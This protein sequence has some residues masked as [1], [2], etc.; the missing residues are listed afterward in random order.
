MKANEFELF[1]STATHEQM[2]NFFDSLLFKEMNL[3]IKGRIQ[4]YNGERKFKY[5]AMKVFPMQ[6]Q[7]E[8]KALLKRLDSYQTSR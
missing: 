1:R 2:N 7:S 6:T 8:N 3:M 4:D 5:Y